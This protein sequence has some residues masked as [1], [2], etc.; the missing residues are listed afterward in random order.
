MSWVKARTNQLNFLLCCLGFVLLLNSSCT[1][2]ENTDPLDLLYASPSPELGSQQDSSQPI[3]TYSEGTATPSNSETSAIT[4]H[5]IRLLNPVSEEKRVVGLVTNQSSQYAQNIQLEIDI[6]DPAN[7]LLYTSEINPVVNSLSPGETVPFVL[8]VLENLPIPDHVTGKIIN[9]DFGGIIQPEI[10]IT[11]VSHQLDIHGNYHVIGEILNNNPDPVRISGL[12][13][14]IFDEDGNLLTVDTSFIHAPYLNPGETSPFRITTEIPPGNINKLEEPHI[15]I[16]AT[17]SPPERFYEIIIDK[18]PNKYLDNLNVFHLV[19][20]V[21]NNSEVPL[22]VHLLAS[23]YDANNRLLDTAMAEL[24][25][26]TISPGEKLPYDFASWGPLASDD[27][28]IETATNFAIQWILQDPLPPESI[29]VELETQNQMIIFDELRGI[30]TGEIVNT[31]GYQLSSTVV[32][33]SL[34]DPATNQILATGFERS[35]RAIPPDGITS[36]QIIIDL[37]KQ[38]SL[39]SSSVKLVAKGT[40][41]DN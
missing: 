20:E 19:G 11:N 24:P 26:A 23:I 41:T 18:K 15:F 35:N 32:I 29:F 36:Y 16:D 17:I 27:L 40:V 10:Q 6:F 12:T 1:R 4:I 8:R 14:S 39:D 9:Y 2:D 21:M 22:S 5:E 34:F 7:N 25:L 28:I 33:A 30:I 13:A 3:P 37:D 38:H 31:S